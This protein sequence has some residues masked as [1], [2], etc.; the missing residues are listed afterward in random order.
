[1]CYQRDSWSTSFEDKR[2]VFDSVDN[3]FRGNSP[4]L[5]S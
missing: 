5:F 1:M 2:V 4:H 3:W